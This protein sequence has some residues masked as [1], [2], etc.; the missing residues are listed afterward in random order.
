MN[1]ENKKVAIVTKHEKE[2]I[3]APILEAN[4]NMETVLIPNLD[5]DIWGTFSGEKER[6]GTA[7]ETVI[8]KTKMISELQDFDFVIAS[9][10]SFFEHPLLPFTTVN[11]EVVCLRSLKDDRMFIGK[12]QSV[13]TNFKKG[14]FSHYEDLLH[15]AKKVNF[16]SHALILKDKKEEGNSVFKALRNEK[17]LKLIFDFLKELNDE[18]YVETDMRAHLNPTRQLVIQEAVNNLVARMKSVCPKC[19]TPD[20]WV[21]H[22]KFDLNCMVCDAPTSLASVE[23]L[24]CKSCAYE[25]EKKIVITDEDLIQAAC[26]RCNP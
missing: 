5:T 8:N 23:V 11:E 9:E 18:V 21:D 20:F 24:H 6:L 10:G 4:F 14:V 7:I 26:E 16:P 1:F 12:A 22:L 13:V 17:H 3:I 2:K 15:F 25:E 19:K